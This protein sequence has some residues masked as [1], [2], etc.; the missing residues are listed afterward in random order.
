MKQFK[1]R[2]ISVMLSLL[3]V[4]S[5]SMPA[6]AANA[7][8]TVTTS[9]KA[10]TAINTAAKFRLSTLENPS[11]GNNNEGDWFIFA[12]QR[13]D[14]EIS[15]K[16]DYTNKYIS[17]VKNNISSLQYPSDYA[18]VI[19]TLTSLGVDCSKDFGGV[20][21]IEK[22]LSNKDSFKGTFALNSI[23][24]LIALNS[25]NY[26]IPSSCS[27]TKE[28]LVTDLLSYK[29]EKTN[30]FYFSTDKTYGTDL[31]TTFMANQALSGCDVSD[32]NLK[33]QIQNAKTACLE[34][35]KTSQSK[36]GAI[37]SYGMDNACTTAQAIVALTEMG[38]DVN[39]YQKDGKNLV[40]GLLSLQDSETNGFIGYT[41]KAD[42][43]TTDQSLYALVAYSRSEQ[44][45][46]TLFDM[47]STDTLSYSPDSFSAKVG[48]FFDN[49]K[50]FFQRLF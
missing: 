9:Q 31:D 16:E 35:I 48:K 22:M 3:M 37:S 50:G 44:G 40:D 27:I 8:E 30:L 41:G 2:I 1:R 32:E 29:D 24:A 49:I 26:D 12:I 14:I 21:L 28:D 43:Q 19:I 15:N 38:E 13:G 25:N 39:S 45:L 17:N 18:R 20:N 47:N 10:L 23:Y 5:F 46:N 7:N 36:S 34:T 11:T 6:L 4:L 33:T 42:I